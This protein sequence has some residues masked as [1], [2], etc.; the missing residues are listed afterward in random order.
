ML[1][2][3]SFHHPS[4][5]QEKVTVCAFHISCFQFYGTYRLLSESAPEFEKEIN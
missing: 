1:L 2:D 4:L 5:T 3:D